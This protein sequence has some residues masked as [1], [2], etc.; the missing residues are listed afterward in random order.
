M[1]WGRI[2][3]MELKIFLNVMVKSI[4]RLKKTK[5]ETKFIPAENCISAKI[6]RNWLK[7]LKLAGI[8]SKVEQRLL[9]FWFAYRYKK[10]RSEWNKIYNIDLNQITPLK[11]VKY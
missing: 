10:F 3:S 6:T 2:E 8:C 1:L 7:C 9:P 4:Y 11:K 5:E